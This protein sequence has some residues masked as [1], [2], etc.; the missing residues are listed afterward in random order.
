METINCKECM[1]TKSFDVEVDELDVTVTVNGL[2]L[3]KE[4]IENAKKVKNGYAYKLS[5]GLFYS[6]S[7]VFVLSKIF[8]SVLPRINFFIL[9]LEIIIVMLILNSCSV[10]NWISPEDPNQFYH[11]DTTLIHQVDSVYS[12]YYDDWY[13]GN[14]SDD[15]NSVYYKLPLYH[16][17]E[18]EKLNNEYERQVDSLKSLLNELP[19]NLNNGKAD[20]NLKLVYDNELLNHYLDSLSNIIMVDSIS[21]HDKEL[22][23]IY[24]INKIKK[25]LQVKDSLEKELL[26]VQNR[27]EKTYLA[28]AIIIFFGLIIALIV[29][30]KRK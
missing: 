21:D 17:E 14:Y 11:E 27:N 23:D 16:N 4:F 29:L 5:D 8:S 6:S 26:S 19:H 3:S 2:T 30:P 25:S 15:S 7:S 12:D 18:M 20:H 9:L 28:L 24:R 22:S 13:G 1:V 10:L